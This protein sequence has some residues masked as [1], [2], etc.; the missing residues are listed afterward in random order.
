[1]YMYVCINYWGIGP[2]VMSVPPIEQLLPGF[3]GEFPFLPLL[4]ELLLQAAQVSAVLAQQ[5]AFQLP[6]FCLRI[7]EAVVDINL[8][9]R[10][11]IPIDSLTAPWNNKTNTRFYVEYE[12]KNTSHIICLSLA[13]DLIT[14]H[15]IYPGFSKC[16]LNY[17]CMDCKKT[18]FNKQ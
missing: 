11:T 13:I 15:L 5:L 17:L 18:V 12:K 16:P 10:R 1:M 3:F 7:Y 4:H 6:V 8:F 2:F 9:F 14:W